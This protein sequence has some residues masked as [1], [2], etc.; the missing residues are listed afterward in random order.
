MKRIAILLVGVGFGLAC[1]A[2]QSQPATA[3]S[4]AS[5]AASDSMQ[6]RAPAPTALPDYAQ[7]IANPYGRD[8][9]LLNGAWH[10]IIDP[11]EH[12]YY[13]YRYEARPDHWG[14]SEKPKDKSDRIEYDFDQSPTLKV[15]GDWNSQRAELTFY[16]GSVWYKTSFDPKPPGSSPGTK[17]RTFL[18]FGA[19]N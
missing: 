13:D 8:P 12:G 18:R 3:P 5:V 10:G 1:R 6:P 4:H 2:P 14:L 19:A 15:P 17:R 11:Y 9:K 16:E 7:L